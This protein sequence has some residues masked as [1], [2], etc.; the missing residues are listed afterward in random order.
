[1][2]HLDADFVRYP[3]LGLS[4]GFGKLNER[5]DKSNAAGLGAFNPEPTVPLSFAPMY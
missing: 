1:M 4:F 2:H 3:P 5:I